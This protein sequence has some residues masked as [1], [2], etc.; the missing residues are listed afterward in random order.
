MLEKPGVGGGVNVVCVGGCG[1]N[2]GEAGCRRSSER[3]VCV[4]VV[5]MLEKP[6]GGSGVNVVG[7]CGGEGGWRGRVGVGE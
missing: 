4:S 2:A 6:G 7:V 3:G 5:E 1:R